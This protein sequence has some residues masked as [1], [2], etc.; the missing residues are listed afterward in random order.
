MEFGFKLTTHGRAVLAACGTLE[1]PLRL[2]RVAFGSGRVGEGTDLADVHELLCY[3]DEGTIGERS[4]ENDRLYLEVRYTNDAQH[5]G[6]GGFL[7]SEFMLYAADP[8]TG[9]ERDLAYAILGDYCQTV[10]GYREGFPASTWT[11]PIT[12]VVSDETEVFVTAASGLVTYD[13]LW[14]MAQVGMLGIRRWGLTIPAEGWMEDAVYGYGKMLELP[15]KRVTERMTPLLTVLPDGIQTA[16]KCGLAHFLETR[17]GALRLWAKREPEGPISTVL[18]LLGDV[19]QILSTGGGLSVLPPAGAEALG[20]VMVREGSG[21]RVDA[22]GVLCVD[23]ATEE[24][25]AEL[26]A[27]GS[28]GETVE[29][30]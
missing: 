1:A 19:G 6:A 22:E 2:T 28:G 30:V 20:G 21:L 10:P 24:E 8:V 4:H 23:A 18:A 16:A 12:I 5:A 26:L 29:G 25:V 15:Q 7:L 17:D 11:F 3:E 13:D 9:E 27:Q 14:S